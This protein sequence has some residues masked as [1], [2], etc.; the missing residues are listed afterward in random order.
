MLF[1]IVLSG[2]FSK[3]S[4][5]L[6]QTHNYIYNAG[7]NVISPNLTTFKLKTA[8]IKNNFILLGQDDHNASPGTIQQKHLDAIAKADLVWLCATSGYIGKSTAMEIGFANACG[9]KVFSQDFIE[10]VPFNDFVIK[11][12]SFEE[13]I[14]ITQESLADGLAVP[15]NFTSL[16]EYYKRI[17]SLRQYGKETPAECLLLMVEEVGELARAIR[18]E[19]GLPRQGETKNNIPNEMADVLLYLVHLANVLDINLI[20]SLQDKEEIN[21]LKF[22]K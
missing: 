8:P 21:A 3:S 22:K 10:E 4:E 1:N 6:V 11:V 15:Q 20:N 17:A 5:A 16:Q 19:T 12:F 2:S 14:K 9:I 18:K 7:H 13:A